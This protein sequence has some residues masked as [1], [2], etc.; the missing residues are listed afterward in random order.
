MTAGAARPSRAPTALSAAV[1]G[2]AAV[3]WLALIALHGALDAS[4]RHPVL[5]GVAPEL[6][7]FVGVCGAPP[8]HEGPG[9]ANWMNGWALMVVAMMLPPALPLL[10]AAWSLG[11]ERGDRH[12]IL[13]TITLAF[14]AVWC[15]AGLVLYGVG[16]GLRVVLLSLPGG[17]G[18]PALWAGLAALS[19]GLFQF[20]PLKTACMDACRSPTSVMMTRW[21]PTAPVA[22][23]LRIGACYGMICVGCCWAMMLLGVFVGAMMLPIMVLTAVMMMLERMLPVVRPLIPLQA[24]IAVALG[25]LLILGALP[26]GFVIE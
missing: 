4:A 16:T 1:V 11:T 10:R 12:Q 2:I 8:E 15:A 24:A 5:E 21:Q 13:A 26:A 18:R 14:V 3:A 22:S 9:L 19:A 7:Q 23:S 25:I 20:T 17:P 6:M